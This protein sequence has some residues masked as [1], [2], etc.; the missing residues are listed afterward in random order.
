MRKRWLRW[1]PRAHDPPQT[2]H[3]G[4]G[5]R[6]GRG[7]HH[8]HQHRRHV[9]LP[10]EGGGG[11]GWRETGGAGDRVS[12]AQREMSEEIPGIG[13]TEEGGVVDHHLAGHGV[14]H[15]GHGGAGAGARGRAVHTWKEKSLLFVKNDAERGLPQA[16]DTDRSSSVPPICSKVLKKGSKEERQDEEEGRCQAKKKE[17][18]IEE[19]RKESGRRSS[20][21]TNTFLST[22]ICIDRH[23]RKITY[24]GSGEAETARGSG[25]SSS[26]ASPQAPYSR[27]SSSTLVETARRS[28]LIGRRSPSP[29]QLVAGRTMSANNCRNKFQIQGNSK[30]TEAAAKYEGNNEL[31]GKV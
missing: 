1:E 16:A 9:E 26:S 20:G 30:T 10:G 22:N 11:E 12:D 4:E 25:S 23:D 19:R 29:V 24:R 3:G 15:H 31:G 6:R 17:T 14:H 7:L 18:N 8:R 28:P 2:R 21:F 13:R 27:A 5:A